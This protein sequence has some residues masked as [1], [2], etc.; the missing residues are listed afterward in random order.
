MK[1]L[2]FVLVLIGMLPVSSFA[3]DPSEVLVVAN[4]FV[5]ESVDLARYY[6]EKRGIPEQ[7]LLKITTTEKESCSRKIYNTEIADPIRERV[8]KMSAI[9][10]LVTVYGV[11]LKVGRP[12]LS[13]VEKK[14]IS[15]LKGQQSELKAQLKTIAKKDSPQIKELKKRIKTLGDRIKVLNKGDYSAAVDSELAL[16]LNKNY[17]LKFWLPNPY[18]VGYQEK[19]LP[20]TKDEVLLV[21]RLDGPSVK[22]VKRIIDDSLFAENK[23]LSGSAYFDAT[24]PRSKKK[25]LGGSAFYNQSLYLAADRIKSGKRMPVVI[26]EEK[27]LFQAGDAPDAALYCGWYSLYTYVDAFDWVPGSVGYHMASQECQTLRGGSGNYWCKRMLEDGVTAVIGPVA[28]PY[29]QAFPVPEIFFAYLTDGYYT[30]AEAYFL[31]LPY[32]SW[33]MV[34]VGDPLYR[35]FKN[36]QGAGVRLKVSTSGE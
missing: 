8:V 19:N 33:R 32:L 18:F 20:F 14:Q 17:D 31:S 10:A 15:A 24:G 36:P 23:G 6:M 29:L 28:E 21:S 2:C 26:N 1:Y 13:K 25:Q 12:E 27:G 35:P 16:L 22:I 3:L 9:R 11:P 4:C 7:N 5:P 34:L 30:L